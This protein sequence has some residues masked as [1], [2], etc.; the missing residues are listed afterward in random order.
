VE[1]VRYCDGKKRLDFK[2]FLE[3]FKNRILKA[4]EVLDSP[5]ER[6]VFKP[7]P[8]KIIQKCVLFQEPMLRKIRS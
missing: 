8:A 4:E 3:M 7:C 6:L 2:R 5:T 1:S